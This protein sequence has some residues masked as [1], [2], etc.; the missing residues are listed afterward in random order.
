[1]VDKSVDEVIRHGTEATLKK[2][3]EELCHELEVNEAQKKPERKVTTATICLA[4]DGR[5]LAMD[6]SAHLMGDLFVDLLQR[7]P[8]LRIVLQDALDKMYKLERI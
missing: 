8:E 4:K 1:M 2:L 5:F 6:G 7:R 3:S